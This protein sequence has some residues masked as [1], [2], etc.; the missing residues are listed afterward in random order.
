MTITHHAA[1]L[2]IG[3]SLAPYPVGQQRNPIVT[4]R[5]NWACEDDARFTGWRAMEA[6]A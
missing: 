3:A 6:I 2:V 4:S 5:Q 1:D